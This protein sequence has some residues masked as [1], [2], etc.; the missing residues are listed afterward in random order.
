M[1]ISKIIFAFFFSWAL[2]YGAKKA[3]FYAD[4]IV[5]VIGVLSY[6]I[7]DIIKMLVTLLKNTPKLIIS[8][9]KGKLNLKED[10]KID[11]EE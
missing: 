9:V 7:D 10:C 6:M 8:L 1:L 3:G 5:G 11:K 2:Y 4:Y